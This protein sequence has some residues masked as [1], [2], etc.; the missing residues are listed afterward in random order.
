MI[1][2]GDS[3]MKKN[4]IDKTAELIALIKAGKLKETEANLHKVQMAWCRELKWE[5]VFTG[6][7]LGNLED[8]EESGKYREILEEWMVNAFVNHGR[9]RDE[10]VTAL[11]QVRVQ[12][13][14]EDDE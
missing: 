4:D 14:L 3:D 10:V 2:L 7:I 1:T 6:P 13:Q 11:D 9:D 12:V 5:Q 8:P